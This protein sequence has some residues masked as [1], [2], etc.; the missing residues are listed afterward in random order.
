[1]ARYR[2]SLA[3]D[4]SAYQGFQRQAGDA[5]TVQGAVEGA[6]AR[7]A[8]Q[9]VSV[10][11]AGRTD[12]GVH[13]TGQVIA[14]DLEWRHS[15]A[16]LLNAI[17]AHLPDDIALQEI[18]QHPGFHPRYDA[19]SRCYRYTVIAAPQPQPLLRQRAWRVNTPLDVAAL[20]AAAQVILGEHDFATFGQAPRG[21]NTVRT[22]FTSAW[23]ADVQPYGWR[24][25][26]VV[27]ANAFLY[28]MVR[29]LVGMQVEVG[30][31]RMTVADMQGALARQDVSL[32]R[33]LAPPQ[34]LVLEC[35]R[36]RE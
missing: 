28:H 33:V 35:V 24:Y 6:L 11:A 17:N 16:A 18:R 29:R 20:N 2:A 10:T 36:Y 19:I 8:G 21:E 14:F 9:P 30:R 25:E 23:T 12:T 15:D 32:A 31:G 13:A 1:M 3:Y 4:G 27:E 34:G 5:P 22:V 26:Y 7:L